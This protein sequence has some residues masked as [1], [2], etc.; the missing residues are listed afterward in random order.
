[1]KV[2]GAQRRLGRWAT[3]AEPPLDAYLADLGW[4][5]WPVSVH[6]WNASQPPRPTVAA[7][8]FVVETFARERPRWAEAGR[9]WHA[10]HPDEPT[11]ITSL[12]IVP[13]DLYRCELRL[14]VEARARVFRE[15]W[16]SNDHPG[17]AVP[18]WLSAAAPDLVWR[19]TWRWDAWHESEIAE[20]TP[21]QRRRLERFGPITPSS[22]TPGYGIVR[23]GIAWTGADPADVS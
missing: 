13:N 23:A 3:T 8:R 5:W 10:E 17:L 20:M 15:E 9:R 14:E 4:D 6:P 21:A 19:P 11:P 1:M 7:R 12:W 22:V 18:L 2:R 16:A